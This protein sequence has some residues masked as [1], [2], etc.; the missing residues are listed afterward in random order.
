MGYPL[1]WPISI[2]NGPKKENCSVMFPLLRYLYIR[3]NRF[4]LENNRI[5]IICNNCLGGFL[6][7]DYKMKFCSPTINL[8]IHAYDYN[9]FLYYIANKLPIV[10]LVD[11]TKDDDECPQGLL[12]GDVRISF[13]HYHS[14]DEAKKKW[15]ERVQRIDYNNLFVIYCQASVRED[16]LAEFDK[17][18]FRHKIAL[19]NKEYPNFS[20]CYVIKGFEK[21]E[22]LGYI[23]DKYK[24]YG[25]NYYD[26]VN[27]VKLFNSVG[28]K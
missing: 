16:V 6:Y 19:V 10:D 22:K 12:N 25:L 9:R 7:H 15:L 1:F 5:T 3:S 18:P 8:F 23:F 27:W 14:F 4:L 20:S 11:I 26:Q 2:E 24:W 28:K 21:E 13:V 17:Q